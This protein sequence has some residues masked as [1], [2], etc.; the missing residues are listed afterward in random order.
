MLH[1]FSL[2]YEVPLPSGDGAYQQWGQAMYADAETTEYLDEIRS[3]VCSRCI[4]KPAGGPPC[5]PLGRRCGVEMHLPQLIGSIHDVHSDFLEDYLSRDRKEICENCAFLHSEICPCPMEYLLALIVEAVESVDGRRRQRGVANCPKSWPVRR[6]I[7][8]LEIEKA[9]NEAK[10]TWSGCD[11]A[12]HFGA[13]GLDLNGWTSSRAETKVREHTETAEDWR[14]AARWLGLVE[15]HAREAEA[16]AAKAVAAA[17]AGYWHGAV[18]H[19]QRARALEFAT[20][21]PLWHGYPLAWQQF[22]R[23]LEEAADAAAPVNCG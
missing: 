10:G 11:W 22:S 14:S 23:L 8:P 2:A 7:T 1:T 4:E 19:A 6:R 5:E 9:F 18:K 21:R 13:S 3:H 15:Q 17:Q 20:G 12:T 16:E